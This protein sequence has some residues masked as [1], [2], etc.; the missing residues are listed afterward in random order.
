MT[1]EGFLCFIGWHDWDRPRKRDYS[2]PRCRR[3][4]EWHK[5]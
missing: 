5:V 1:W 3:C 4:G 2:T